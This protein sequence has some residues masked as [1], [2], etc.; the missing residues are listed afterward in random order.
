ME[1]T[2]SQQE[3]L[4]PGEVCQL[5]NCSRA[6]LRVMVQAGSIRRRN[7]EVASYRRYWRA[8]VERLA[9]PPTKQGSIIG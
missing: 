5:L 8:D 6:S 4:T 2:T 7:S 1:T 9:A 3:W